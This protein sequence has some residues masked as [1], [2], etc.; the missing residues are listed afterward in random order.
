MTDDRTT[1]R[2]AV[3]MMRQILSSRQKRTFA[4]LLGVFVVMG[5]LEVVGVASIVPF[6]KLV[7][8]P[9]AIT[10]NR[11]LRL[12]YEW[13]GFETRRTFLL[14]TGTV[15]LGLL[16]FTNMTTVLVK[17]AESRFLWQTIH[18]LSSRLFTTYVHQPYEFYLARNASELGNEVLIEVQQLVQ[19]VLLPLTT[20]ISR[21]LITVLIL[22]LL[23]VA[24]PFIAGTVLVVLGAVYLLIYKGLRTYIGRLGSQRYEL[25]QRRFKIASETLSGIRTIKM[26]GAENF[27]EGRFKNVSE[28]FSR[29]HP[30]HNVLATSTRYFVETIAFG[31]LLLVVLSMLASNETVTETL[32][33]LSLY[34]LA[35]YRLLPAIQALYSAAT[36]FQFSQPIIQSIYS[37]LSDL[38]DQVVAQKDQFERLPFTEK[39]ELRNISYSYPRT[40]EMVLEN[41]SISIS[42]GTSVAIVGPTGAGKTT[43]VNLI[44]GFLRPTAGDLCLDDQNVVDA[45]NVRRWQNMTGYVPQD[46][47]LFDDTVA[48]NI[49]FGIAR[50][51][52]DIGRV[53]W[54]AEIAKIDQFVST[55]LP[56]GYKTNV[57]EGGVR[58]S[59][60]QRQRVGVARALYGR[61]SVLI[62]DEA[63]SA[64]DSI[65]EGD[66]FEALENVDY[67]ITVI[68]IAH[69]ISTVR[70][71][72]KI[73]LVEHGR[74]SARGTYDELLEESKL[75]RGMAKLA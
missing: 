62:L 68:M 75:F 71:C 31:G 8:D 2:E 48:S 53:R 51:S 65:T 66:V 63:T 72:D 41:V 40:Q 15:M 45:S 38:E 35:G 55:E 11:W 57:G 30:K 28:R 23:I 13:S 27:F 4:W 69:R 61:P 60:G 25:N 3:R 6:M 7:V 46:I 18:D 43:L 17:W 32:P 24:D 16:A 26:M 12:A 9:E 36:T 22:A 59:G 20:L 50:D 42:K 52:I 39:I 5:I 19:N 58:L 67:D 29:V 64:L 47:I 37:D 33:L 73:Y 34:A 44:L 14:A 10:N 54:A 74:V 56:E 21:G 49:A 1:L 70:N